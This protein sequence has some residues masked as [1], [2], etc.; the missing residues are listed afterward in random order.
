MS[1][2]NSL[3]ELFQK[4]QQKQISSV[5]F[6]SDGYLG[7]NK[8]SSILFICRESNVNGTLN[9]L[10]AEN[11]NNFWMK[12]VIDVKIK[13]NKKHY[14]ENLSNSE[15]SIQTKFYN[16]LNLAMQNVINKNSELSGCSLTD[17]AYMNINKQGGGYSCDLSFLEDY[18]KNYKDLIIDEIN[19]LSPKY[20]VLC[21]KLWKTKN[22]KTQIKEILKQCNCDNNNIYLCN[23]HPSS[24]KQL[25]E[26][27]KIVSFVIE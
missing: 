17:C 24:R 3:L 7:N 20:I 5:N 13:D 18:V 2:S 15:K 8:K 14:G 11:Y 22:G 12:N 27:A 6:I 9:K 1:N 16:Y 25:E 10:S 19:I 23:Y 4:W 26:A 21:G